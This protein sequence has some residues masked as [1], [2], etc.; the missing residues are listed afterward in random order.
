MN[1]EQLQRLPI[2]QLDRMAFG[3]VQ[4][5]QRFP[6]DEIKIRYDTDYQNALWYVEQHPD[7]YAEALDTEPVEV[8]LERGVYWLEDG[9]HR[10]VT[11]QHRGDRDILAELTIK[12]NP[13][14]VLMERQAR[15]LE[16]EYLVDDS[17]ETIREIARQLRNRYGRHTEV[18]TRPAW[19]ETDELW[20][21]F[22]AFR[23]HLEE[24]D[25]E[26]AELAISAGERIPPIVTYD[27]TIEHGHAALEAA[28]NLGIPMVPIIEAF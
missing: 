5:V 9:H 22:V 11:A 12:D 27:G 16:P 8:A 25:V 1:V 19:V 3:R 13:V 17:H 15:L 14:K 21:E 10:Y 24:N 26:Q 4:G 20:D 2:E 18:P 23:A 7:D 6:L 28:H